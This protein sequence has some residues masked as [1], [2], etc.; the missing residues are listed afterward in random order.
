[1]PPLSI[2]FVSLFAT[3]HLVGCFRRW[4]VRRALPSVCSFAVRMNEGASA[5]EKASIC[6]WEAMEK[7]MKAMEKRM[8]A[9]A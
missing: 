6:A 7:R 5:S 1:M 8:K 9:N 4:R 2:G 3:P